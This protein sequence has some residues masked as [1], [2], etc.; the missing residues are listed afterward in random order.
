LDGPPAHHIMAMVANNG[1]PVQDTIEST[2]L[3][4]VQSNPI[5]ATS[6]KSNERDEF[7]R[8]TE[9][10]S[11]PAK[12]LNTFRTVTVM[13][14]L[15]VSGGFAESI[16]DNIA[17]S[18]LL[19]RF[20]SPIEPYRLKS[21]AE[22][23][24]QALVTQKTDWKLLDSLTD[25]VSVQ[26]ALFIAALNTTIVATAIPKICS[27][28]ESAAGYSW[29]GASYTIAT[30]AV[31]PIWAKFSDIWGRKPILLTA[32]ALYS[33]SSITCAVSTSMGMLVAGRALQGMAGGGLSSIIN[34]VISDLFSMRFALLMLK[35]ISPY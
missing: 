27:D 9:V 28:L 13:I 24:R 34:I 17:S 29:I 32:V 14:A 1:S 4:A 12:P 5:V 35:L 22:C 31:G 23:T 8:V 15:F 10:V 7:D 2:E 33:V 18:P 11:E 30:T 20:E 19:F 3:R 6:I 25:F 21:P 16:L 26:S